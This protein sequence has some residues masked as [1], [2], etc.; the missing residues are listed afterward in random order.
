MR[1]ALV[2]LGTTGAHL[3][4]QLIQSPFTTIALHDSDEHRRRRVVS[5]VRAVVPSTVEVTD[6]PPD[7]DDPPDVVVIASPTGTHLRL[8]SAMMEAGSNVVSLADDPGEVEVLLALDRAATAA[9]RSVVVGAGFAPGLSCLLARYA[10]DQLD[11]VDVISV[12]KAGTGGPACARQHH[13]AL[14]GSGH[15]W[16]DGA[17]VLRRGGSGRD[18]AWFPEPFGARD[19]YRAALP[20]PMLLQ[21]Q[22][23]EARRI[24]ARMAATRRDRLTAGLPMLRPPHEDGGPGAVRV[25][26]RGRVGRAAETVIL[27]VMDHPSVAAATVAAVAAAESAAGRAPVGAHGLAHWDDPRP[28]LSELRRRGVKVASFAGLLDPVA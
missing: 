19:C 20:S 14:Q 25:E 4:R 28:I 12:Y 5:A 15:E 7:R 11:T 3:A 17:W 18:L 13:R 21:R 27:G 2:G 9:G 10:A 22:Y 1:A 16:I 6:E 26:V 23:P 24:S 8:A